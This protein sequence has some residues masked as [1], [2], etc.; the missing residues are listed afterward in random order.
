MRYD[1]PIFFQCVTSG[2]YNA[3]TG[4]YGEDTVAEVKKYA[5]VTDSGVET[6]KLI[7]GDIKQGSKTIRLQRAYAEPF[8]KIRIGE[9][10]YNV[11][12]SRFDKNFVVSEVQ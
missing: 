6:M 1:K 8:D 2:A 5:S 12:F 3:T 4:D 10:I 9:K 7:Y 11:D